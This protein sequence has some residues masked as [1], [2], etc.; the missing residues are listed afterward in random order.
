[1]GG[2]GGGGGLR[3]SACPRHALAVEWGRSET[4]G[5]ISPSSVFCAHQGVAR[6]S[7]QEHFIEGTRTGLQVGLGGSAHRPVY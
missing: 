2:G 1:M 4:A 5:W 6:M 7:L 3:T